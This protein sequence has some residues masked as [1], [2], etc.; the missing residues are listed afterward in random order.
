V[1]GSR[2]DGPEGLSAAR[3]DYGARARLA[4]ADALGASGCAWGQLVALLLLAYLRRCGVL[5]LAAVQLALLNQAPANPTRANAAT[6]GAGYHP[7]PLLTVAGAGCGPSCAVVPLTRLSGREAGA[8][9]DAPAYKPVMTAPSPAT[10]DQPR[11]LVLPTTNARSLPEPARHGGRLPVPTAQAQ[12]NDR[13]VKAAGFVLGLGS[14][15][16]RPMPRS[17]W[18]WST[19]TCGLVHLVD[20]ADIDEISPHLK[21]DS[22]RTPVGAAQ[23]RSAEASVPVPASA[24]V[25]Q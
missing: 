2:A 20:N 3:R 5:P 22:R 10:D 17:W 23:R 4:W 18:R 25:V 6:W 15:V 8:M 11:E 19:P 14:R 9:A 7:V 16:N 13:Q 1:A 21:T 12:S 24:C